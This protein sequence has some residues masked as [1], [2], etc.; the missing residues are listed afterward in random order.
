MYHG[1]QDTVSFRYC[2][3]HSNEAVTMTAFSICILALIRLC[4]HRRSKTTT[5]QSLE[6]ESSNVCIVNARTTRWNKLTIIWTQSLVRTLHHWANKKR[7]CKLP[8][9]SGILKISLRLGA[10]HA[11]QQR[12]KLL[13]RQ[14]CRSFKLTPTLITIDAKNIPA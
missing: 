11:W 8:T 7:N 6:S 4:P 14:D 10:V 9:Q 13:S 12:N 2:S 5:A 3:K 1:T